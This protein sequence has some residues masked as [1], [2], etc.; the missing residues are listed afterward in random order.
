MRKTDTPENHNT[1]PVERKSERKLRPYRFTV[2]NGAGIYRTNAGTLKQARAEL[3][4]FFGD[5]F[6]S[7]R[8]V[9]PGNTRK[10]QSKGEEHAA[11]EDFDDEIPF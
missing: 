11:S 9:R 6:V 1:A 10:R 5:E 7:A 4:H 8:T 2:R 3:E